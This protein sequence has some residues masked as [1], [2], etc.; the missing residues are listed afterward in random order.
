MRALD[1]A[2]PLAHLKQ[3]FRLPDGTIYLNGNSLGPLPVATP[4]RVQRTLEEWGSVGGTGWSGCGWMDGPERLGDRLAP[5]IGAGAGEVL[6]ADTTSIALAKLVGAVLGARPTRRVVLS[7]TDNFPSDLYAAEGAARLAGGLLRVVERSELAGSLHADVALC[8]VTQV[9]YRSGYRYDVET[10]TQAVHDAGALMLWD[11]CHSAGVVPVGCEA[12]GVDLAVGC[13]YKYLNAGPGAPAFVYV[14]RSLQDEL[15]NPVPGWLG[16]A[17]PF[18]FE[19]EWRPAQGIRRFLTS[20]PPVI[21][22][23][24][25]DAALDAIEDTTIDALWHKSRTLGELF[26]DVVRGE[27]APTLEIASPPASE[28]R[29]AHVALRHPRAQELADALAAR[30]VIID[31]RPPDLCRFGL[32]PYLSYEDVFTAARIVTE[33]SSAAAFASG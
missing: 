5:L 33:V 4:S 17:A 14:R 1:D 15:S 7:T 6:V 21:A 8:C 32:A 30:G 13:T 23:A 10:V 29:G 12:H 25:L 28:E 2:D 20:T 26:V 9:D 27:G 22:L 24:G 18:G 11:L 3:R 19:Q 16:H 31:V